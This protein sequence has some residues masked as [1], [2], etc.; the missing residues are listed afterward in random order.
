MKYLVKVFHVHLCPGSEL[1]NRDAF[2]L[3]S[4]GWCDRNI[5]SLWAE[6]PAA[7]HIYPP[8]SPLSFQAGWRTVS[9]VEMI[10]KSL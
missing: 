10:S 3:C 9:F 6:R 1:G 5:G 4:Q 2:L 8:L 7:S